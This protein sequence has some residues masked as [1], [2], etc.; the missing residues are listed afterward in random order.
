MAA[1]LK[2]K[3]A[4]NE[5][6]KAQKIHVSC[7]R[8]SANAKEHRNQEFWLM[9]LSTDIDFQM[10]DLRQACRLRLWASVENVSIL[11][12]RRH[13]IPEK[14]I[15]SRIKKLDPPEYPFPS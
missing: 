9:P 10:A 13:L 8:A 14:E 11:D 4:A 2:A 3:A 5:K 7:V 6:L 12:L 15:L 1:V